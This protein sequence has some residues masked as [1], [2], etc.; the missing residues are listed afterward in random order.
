MGSAEGAPAIVRLRG[1]SLSYSQLQALS[2]VELD[3]YPGEVHAVVGE[4]GAGKSSIARVI[5]GFNEPD[6]GDIEVGGKQYRS[7]SQRVARL[8]G[9]SFVTQS[10]PHVNSFTVAENI[11]LDHHIGLLPLTSRGRSLKTVRSF[12]A[13]LDQQFD[14][15]PSAPLSLLALSDRVLVDILKHLFRRPELLI[16]DEAL[17]KLDS[18]S[19]QKIQLLLTAM[20]KDGMAVLFITH[21]IDDIFF[22]ADKVSVVRNGRILCTENVRDIDRITLIKLAYT[23]IANSRRVVSDQ[24]FYQ[25]LKYNE[26]ILNDLPINLLVFD[27]TGVLKLMNKEAQKMFGLPNDPTGRASIESLFG[28]SNPG[29]ASRLMRMITAGEEEQLY[30]VPLE[31]EELRKVYNI[32]VFPITEGRSLM[33]S[34]VIAEDITYQEKLREQMRI[35][36]NLA[37]VG[38]LAAGVAHEINNPLEIIQYHLENILFNAGRKEVVDATHSIAEEIDS[39]SEIVGN[40][41]SLSKSGISGREVFDLRSAAIELLNLVRFYAEKNNLSIDFKADAGPIPVAGDKR[42]IK[43]VILNLMKNSFEAMPDGGRLGIELSATPDVAS[44][45][46]SDSGKGIDEKHLTSIFIPFFSTKDESSQNLGLGLSLC[47]TIV[48]RHGGSIGVE[49]APG[50]GCVFTIALPVHRSGDAP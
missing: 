47:Y 16:L 36:E 27:R 21:R 45:R 2:G 31:R 13:G 50:G 30:Q 34:I 24:S 15:D 39:I 44:L 46:I 12:L 29:L 38:L 32:C 25:I 42:E 10:N 5:S 41:V 7:V 9:I 1:V 4:H 40:L 23:Q 33:G 6:S 28:P 26:A 8:N 3:F 37:S 17:E 11:L 35:S 20:K 48:K 18:R 49:N 22:F 19:L 43:Q 14:L